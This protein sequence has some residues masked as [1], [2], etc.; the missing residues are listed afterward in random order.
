MSVRLPRATVLGLERGE[1]EV[2]EGL[3]K[4]CGEGA[5]REQHGRSFIA[6]FYTKILS[7]VAFLLDGAALTKTY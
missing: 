6:E 2:Q 7:K 3:E 5:N 1:R 4:M